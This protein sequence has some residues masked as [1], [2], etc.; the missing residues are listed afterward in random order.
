[1]VPGSARNWIAA[2]A[3]QQPQPQQKMKPKNTTTPHLRKSTGP[4]AFAA[5]FSSLAFACFALSPMVQAV[6]PAPDGG[7]PNENTAEGDFALN[8]L[9]SGS[10]NTALG[11]QA[12]L[13]NT[14][15][16][17]NTANGVN[18][19]FSNTTGS[20]N[21]ANGIN[22]LLVNKT[23]N[24]NIAEGDGALG[25]NTGSF[26]TAVGFSLRCDG[27]RR[28]R[29]SSW[30]GSFLGAIQERDQADG[31][32]KRSDPRAQTCDVPVQART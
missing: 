8:S 22:A 13:N 14:T 9:T 20:N 26:N 2:H 32:S 6:S 4:V 7:Y 24:G 3:A 11:F 16:T 27:D 30:Y 1:M 23:G 12:L 15:G 25:S 19:L 28:E 18:A 17:Q 5:R 31:Q 10:L 21:T 29:R